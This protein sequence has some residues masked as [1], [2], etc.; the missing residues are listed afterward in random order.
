V[1][2]VI[3]ERADPSLV[4][5]GWSRDMTIDTGACVTVAKTDFVTGWPERL[6]N[7]RYT[8]KTVSGTALHILK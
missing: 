3:T 4:I 2:R 5:Q 1:L 6:P 8:L 7:Q